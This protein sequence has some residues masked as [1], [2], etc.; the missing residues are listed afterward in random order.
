MI[1]VDGQ[2]ILDTYWWQ[3]WEAKDPRGLD[4]PMTR[5]KNSCHGSTIKKKTTS[6]G[7]YDREEWKKQVMAGLNFKGLLS[8][9]R[10][11]NLIIF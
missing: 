7:G 3:Q 4:K 9:T 6:S 8:I 11:W 2:L 10:W 5:W 1:R